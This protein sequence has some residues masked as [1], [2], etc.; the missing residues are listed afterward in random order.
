MEQ[1]KSKNW[2]D[3]LISQVLAQYFLNFLKKVKLQKFSRQQVMMN[4]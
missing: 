3:T 2:K 1:T 4:W